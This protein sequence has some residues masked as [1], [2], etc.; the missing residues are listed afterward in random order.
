MVYRTQNVFSM[1]SLTILALAHVCLTAPFI[2]SSSA[3][4]LGNAEAANVLKQRYSSTGLPLDEYINKPEEVYKWVEYADASFKTLFGGTAHVLNVTSQTWLDSSRVG[5]GI[6]GGKGRTN[7]WTHMVIVIVPK[8]LV[9]RN[10]S[11]AYLTG[12]CNANPKVPSKTDEDVLVA[13]EI[14]HTTNAIGIVVFQIPNCPMYYPSV[15]A[16]RPVKDVFLAFWL[17][18]L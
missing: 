14:S 18:F 15:P 2:P 13:D 12:D 11:L 10:L 6:N 4:E 17:E 1:A 8:N 7:V 5:V 9:F 16:K 3:T